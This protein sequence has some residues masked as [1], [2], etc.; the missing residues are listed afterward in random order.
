[1]QVLI[2]GCNGLLGQN[3]IRTKP[4]DAEIS[5]LGSGMENAAVLQTSLVSYR[6]LDI[7]NRTA[8][9]KTLREIS[10]DFI[11]NAAAITDVD[12]CERD[13]ALCA[14]VN[15][16]AV[17]WMA[18]TGIPL[19]QISTDY[20]FD[21]ESGPYAETDV[22]GPLSYYGITKL[23]SEK[24]VLAGSPKSLVLRTMTLWGKGHGMKTSF[25]E[26]VQNS[27]SAGK[28]IKIVTDQWGNPTLAEDLALS[29]WKLILA[30]KNGIYHAVGSEWNS[31][32]EW[33]VAIAEYYGLDK[34]LITPCVT[35][36]LKQ[37]ARRPL[38][39][40]LKIDKL[41]AATGFSPRGVTA[42]LDR[43]AELSGIA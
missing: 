25:V 11:I 14:L 16:D 23:E 15:R 27:L 34:S 5:L 12:L 17:G 30:G 42:Q 3:L 19:V 7:T 21:G 24:L 43:I 1:M 2:I 8:L 20:I 31:R 38:K 6:S 4:V 32:F 39:S 26:F 35:A 10:P 37:L 40:G 29:V 9:E 18:S 41:V 13:Q 28:T 36:D 33:A 22:T